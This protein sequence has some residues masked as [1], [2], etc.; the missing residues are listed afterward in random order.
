MTVHKYTYEDNELSAFICNICNYVQ[1]REK[2]MISHMTYQHEMSENN[3]K[4]QK[5]ILSRYAS[6]E[7]ELPDKTNTEA[8]H[9]SVKKEIN[10][11]EYDIP[12]TYIGEKCG[13]TGTSSMTNT[14]NNWEEDIPIVYIG[15]SGESDATSESSA[16]QHQNGL[17][18]SEGLIN[19][20]D[21]STATEEMFV[22]ETQGEVVVKQ[23]I[24]AESSKFFFIL[25]FF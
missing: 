8:A 2:N 18:L 12:I 23:E 22:C 10:N 15:P 16:R 21:Q 13:P 17:H 9:V 25:I 14:N 24:D 1:V 3:N 19:Q 5:I 6:K 7:S 4:Y 20:D 11:C